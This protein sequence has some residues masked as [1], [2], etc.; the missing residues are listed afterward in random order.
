MTGAGGPG[1]DNS[2]VELH[3]LAKNAVGA[4]DPA[5]D[6]SDSAKNSP[7]PRVLVVDDDR[8]VRWSVS[9]ILTAH[10]YDV[11]EA[12]DGR[13]AMQALDASPD[14]DL[15]LLDLR[16]PDTDDFRLLARIRE[17]T[18]K[19]PVILMTAFGTREVAESAEALG[20][21]FLCKPFDLNDLASRVDRTLGRVY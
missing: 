20:A 2:R 8:L 6:F 5:G 17:K 4:R 16:L 3:M 21:R 12:A 19:V 10:G 1:F 9:E 14:T 7:H 11:D 13:S 15:V 18:P